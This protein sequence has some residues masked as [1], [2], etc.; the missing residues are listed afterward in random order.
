MGRRWPPSP[1]D[2]EEASRICVELGLDEVVGRMPGGMGQMIGETGWQLSQGERGRLYLA[3]TL[4]QGADV[5]VL[6]ESFAALDAETMSRSLD[7]AE[8]R[9][10]TMVVITHG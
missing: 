1:D 2:L 5:V 6:D 10:R 9:A 3:R 8:R 7:C 4:L